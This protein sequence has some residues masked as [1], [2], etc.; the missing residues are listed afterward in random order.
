MEAQ[1]VS[2]ISE[3]NTTDLKLKGFKAYRI[4]TSLHPIPNYS[5]RDF[6]KFVS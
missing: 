4:E 6:I 1:V 3:F 2:T 5:R